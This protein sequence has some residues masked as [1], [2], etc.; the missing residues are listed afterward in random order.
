MHKGAD[1]KTVCRPQYE[2]T[3]PPCPTQAQM[4]N[5]DITSDLINSQNAQRQSAPYSSLEVVP[6]PYPALEVNPGKSLPELVRLEKETY[7]HSQEKEA[8]IDP[9][10]LGGRKPKLYERFL[11]GKWL[12][13]SILIGII[14]LGGII[15]GA[16]GV[17]KNTQK[18]P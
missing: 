16:V 9:L 15:G 3:Y 10:V 6:A 13:L 4:A 17:T 18:Q 11:S 2:K 14:V 8:Y 5:S 12:W 7:I 1:D